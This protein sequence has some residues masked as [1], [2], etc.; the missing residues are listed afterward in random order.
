MNMNNLIEALSNSDFWIAIAFAFVV[1]FLIATFVQDVY[2]TCVDILDEELVNYVFTDEELYIGCMVYDTVLDVIGTYCGT[3]L[4]VDNNLYGIVTVI[5]D[6]KIYYYY[7][8]LDN[9]KMVEE[10]K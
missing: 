7:P 4:G 8:V 9:L 2:N 10:Q 6:N 3:H 1:S 5:Q